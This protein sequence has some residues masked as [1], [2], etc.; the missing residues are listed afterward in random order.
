MRKSCR[1]ADGRTQTSKAPEYLLIVLA[2]WSSLFFISLLYSSAAVANV[3]N[4][5]TPT[6][7][8]SERF[9]EILHSRTNELGVTR[10]QLVVF[11]SQ[12]VLERYDIGNAGDYL[13][14]TLTETLTAIAVMQLVEQGQWSLFD[15]LTD[16][17]PDIDLENPYAAESPL[18]IWHL[19]EHSSGLD[20]RR[21]KSHIATSTTSTMTLEERLKREQNPLH[22]RWRPGAAA[23]PSALNYAL[24]AAML[25]R[26]YGQPWQAVIAE[27]VSQPLQFSNATLGPPEEPLPAGHQGVPATAVEP[28]MRTF[29]E[30]EG[31][32]LDADDLVKLGQFFL[33]GG[34]TSAKAVL[35]RDTIENMQQ[36]RSTDAADAGLAYGYAAG[37]DTRANQGLWLGRQSN[38][39][40]YSAQLRYDP[41]LGIG[42][43]ILLDHQT[44]LPAIESLLWSHRL[45]EYMPAP[46][47]AGGGVSI[48]PRWQGWYKLINPEHAWLAPLEKAFNLAY[49]TQENADLYLREPLKPRLALRSVDGSRLVQHNDNT[50]IGLLF[51]DPAGTQ[52]LQVYHDVRERVEPWQAWLPPVLIVFG[53]LLLASSIL[54]PSRYWPVLSA[55]RFAIAAAWLLLLS[56][57]VAGSLSLEQASTDNWR[58][59]LLFGLTL[60]F[61]LCAFAAPL[62]LVS[63]EVRGKRQSELSGHSWGTLY[64]VLVVLASSGLAAWFVSNGW[65]ALRTWAW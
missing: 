59:V 55:R 58:S 60:L 54:V 38:L 20:Q 16:R 50:P 19:L 3:A 5:Q 24:L 34:A 13:I 22:V 17:L 43:L 11:D 4:A 41:Q 26:Y 40:G 23:S 1:T 6:N 62:L 64:S 36:P 57:F 27:Q 14:G 48:E 12:Q 35:R 21:F 32:W 49:V 15:S 52:R 18:L 30:A 25:E 56:I 51:S 63:A 2:L 65:F 42:Y 39:G 61:P 45:V 7:T 31:A 8:S 10:A 33:S 47:V 9:E 29:V 53:V 37:L 28:S 46:L 44:L